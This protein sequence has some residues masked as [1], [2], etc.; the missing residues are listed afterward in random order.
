M[1]AILKHIPE[2]RRGPLVVLLAFLGLFGATEINRLIY[3]HVDGAYTV[4]GIRSASR[5][6]EVDDVERMS[7]LLALPVN[8]AATD[9]EGKI[10]PDQLQA[11]FTGPQEAVKPRPAVRPMAQV[12]NEQ[13]AGATR[14]SAIARA[15]APTAA[16]RKP[17]T[18]WGALA[19]QAIAVQAATTR[20]AFINGR[21]YTVGSEV[22]GVVL[23]GKDEESVPRLA[24]VSQTA[25]SIAVG[26]G[27]FEFPME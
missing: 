14:R 7:Q 23:K 3:Q 1:K 13:N 16:A 11:L 26:N 24:S 18:D 21:F 27:Q 22:D 15:P 10:T 8:A 19:R 6:K 4:G 17:K 25:V 5:G 12:N 20:G 9:G 2:S